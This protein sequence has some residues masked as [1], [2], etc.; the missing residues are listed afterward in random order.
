[1]RS[2]DV[3]PYHL[4]RFDRVIF[5]L[6]AIERLQES[7]KKTAS[8]RRGPGNGEAAKPAAAS[9]KTRKRAR[10]RAAEEVA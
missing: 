6:P 8:S 5:A 3:H 7:L 4:L 9:S 1:M 10:T 2:S